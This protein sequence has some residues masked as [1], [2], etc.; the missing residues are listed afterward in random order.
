MCASPLFDFTAST[1]TPSDWQSVDDPVMGGVSESTLAATN[2]GAAFTGTVSLEQ[3]GGFCSVRA[4]EGP[5]DLSHADGL[6]LRLRGDGHRYWITAYTT[7]GGPISY[8]TPR[9][10]PERWTDVVV[11]FD[12]LTPYRRGTR[13]PDAPPFT[14]ARI[15]TVGV[16]IADKQAGPFRLEIKWIRAEDTVT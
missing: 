16:L 9:R 14:P 10:P 6:R 4:P 7:S 15:R 12:D 11:P 13:L 1:A 8:R 5:Y 2:A 3:G